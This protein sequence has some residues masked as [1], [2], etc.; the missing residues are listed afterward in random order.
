[1][2]DT[3]SMLLS[4]P[5][6]EPGPEDREGHTASVV[7]QHIFIFGGTWTDEEDN[8]LYM[9]DLH[10]LDTSQL[11][12]SRPPASGA[13]PIEREGHTATTVGH[14]IFVFG[15][16]WVDDEDN[17]TYLND[18]YIFDVDLAAWLQADTT[19]EP[20]IQREGHTASVIGTQMVVFGGAGLDSEERS[21]NLNDLHILDTQSMAWTQ[22]HCGGNIPQVRV[23]VRGVLGSRAR[24]LRRCKPT[25]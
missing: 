18:L 10:V 4:S 13:I 16:T 12:W 2:L 20:P 1:V 21:V 6:L 5:T 23:H 8:T 24:C 3:E 14:R 9:N 17:S 19:G 22:P 15:G 25:P 7:G 11:C